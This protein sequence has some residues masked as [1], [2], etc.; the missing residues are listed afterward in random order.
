MLQGG[1]AGPAIVAR[2]IGTKRTEA[3]PQLR[4]DP[5]YFLYI[6]QEGDESL[7]PARCNSPWL[8]EEYKTYHH[9]AL[10]PVTLVVDAVTLPFQI[11]ANL[12]VA[13]TVPEIQ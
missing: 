7:A 1:H 13:L 10:L 9:L 2:S 4:P 8:R 12:W 3:G 11:A 5:Y 6:S